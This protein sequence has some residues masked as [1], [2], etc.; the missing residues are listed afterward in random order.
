MILLQNLPFTDSSAH[1]L[2][3]VFFGLWNMEL[4]IV[5]TSLSFHGD[6][7]GK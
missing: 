2:K 3:Y 6:V 7:C 5:H 1:L 4:R